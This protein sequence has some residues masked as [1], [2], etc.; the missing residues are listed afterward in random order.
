M[1]QQLKDALIRI[2]V[3]AHGLMSI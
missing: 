2:F 3:L 1:N